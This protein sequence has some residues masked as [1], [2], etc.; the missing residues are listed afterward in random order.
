[1]RLLLNILSYLLF[2]LLF[3]F[4]SF[5]FFYK[6]IIHIYF[7]YENKIIGL[8]KDC[9]TGKIYRLPK[10]CFFFSPNRRILF[11][12]FLIVKNHYL[13][14]VYSVKEIYVGNKYGILLAPSEIIVQ[15]FIVQFFLMLQIFFFKT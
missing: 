4:S 9:L 11:T 13:K 14:L 6:G 12:N 5:V 15:N 8:I 2:H 10:I 1:M 7:N 3:C